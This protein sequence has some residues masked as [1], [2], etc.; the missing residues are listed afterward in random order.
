LFSACHNAG[1][2]HSSIDLSGATMGTTYSV[3]LVDGRSTDAADAL[4]ASIAARLMLIERSMSTYIEDSEL[5][6]FNR[7]DSK[8]WFKVSPMLCTAIAESLSLSRFTD[9]NFDITIGPLVN[10]WGFGATAPTGHFPEDTEIAAA[11]DSTGFE[12]LATD[13]QNL[14]IRK[15]DESVYVDLSAY[16]KGLAVDKI[17][18]LL[19]ENMVTNYVVEIGGEIRTRGNNQSGEPWRIAIEKPIDTERT[20]QRIVSVSDMAMATSGYYRNFFIVDG[21][22]YSHTIDPRSGRPV[23]HR[24]AAVTVISE[25]AAEADALA[26]ALLVM[27]PVAG[28]KFA[29][30]HEIAALFLIDEEA[31][32]RELLTARFEA[33]MQR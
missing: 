4:E 20:V 32:I 3:T 19:D 30:Q 26:T 13:C 10:L 12:K 7:S 21:Q 22:R 31:A 16:A 2:E 11:L 29:A 23:N 5:S 27:G 28:P 9:G 25:R 8:S 14:V 15:S 18:D 24:L 33:Q 1:N 6:A 17:S